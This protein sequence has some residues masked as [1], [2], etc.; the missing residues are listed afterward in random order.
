MLATTDAGLRPGRDHSVQVLDDGRTYPRS[1]RRHAALRPM[2]PGRAAG[3]TVRV[4][5]SVRRDE[6][7]STDGPRLRGTP[8]L[9]RA[10]IS[11][12]RAGRNCR[13]RLAGLR[14]AFRPVRTEPGR[15]HDAVRRPV[16]EPARGSGRLRSSRSRACASTPTQT[17]PTRDAR[18]SR[19]TGST[20]TA[21]TSL[22]LVPPPGV[23]RG[24]RHN[25]RCGLVLWQDDE[26]Y[27]VVN[28][29]LDDWLVGTSISTFYRIRGHEDMYD[30]VWTLTGE[31]VTWGVPHTLRV[32]FDG[33]RFIAYLNGET[34]ALPGRSRCLS[35][36]ALSS[37]SRRSRHRQRGVGR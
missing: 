34:G 19:S 32:V 33:Y 17:G 6:D 31:N 26:N 13:L 1:P 35:R 5:E 12:T 16:V 28:T 21:S 20:R 7:G 23:G 24:Q 30:A 29:W 22:S 14:R 2:V 27:L 3:R 25:G 8:A 10:P 9:V 36:R 15:H 37:R 4:P 18:S 11:R